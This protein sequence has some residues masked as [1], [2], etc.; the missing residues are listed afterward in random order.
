MKLT[1]PQQLI[2]DS[3]KVIG[4]SVAVMCGIMTVDKVYP[5]EDVVEAIKTIYKTNDALNYCLDDSGKEP[6]MFYKSPVGRKVNVVRVNS[7]SE[8]E[9]IGEKEAATPFDLNGW[10]SELSAV[11]HPEGYGIVLK[12]HHILGDAWSMSLIGTQL[13]AILEGTP[14]VR[15]SYEKYINAEQ[16]Y[17]SSKRYERDR[18]FFLNAFE[19]CREPL[20]LS[21]KQSKSYCINTVSRS[22]SKQM[23]TALSEYAEKKE[24]SEFV[25]LL[26][27]FAVLYGRLKNCAESFF[28]GMPVLN[29][30]SEMDM[31]TVGMYVNT[32]PVPVHFDY[33]KSFSDNLQQIQNTVFSVFKH[34]KFNYNDILKAVSEEYGFQ[35][36]LYDCTVNYETD[37][38][39][40]TKTMRSKEYHREMQTESLQLFIQHRN[41]GEELVVE[42]TFHRDVFDACEMER[43]HDMFMRVLNLIMQDDKQPLKDISIID[44]EEEKLLKS[45]N[46]TAVPYDKTKSVYDLFEEQA[47]KTPDKTAVAAADCTLSYSQLKEE[48]SRL[49]KG[50][51]DKGIKKGDIVA[52]CL[53]RNSKI[54]CA[55]LAV[56]QTGAAYLPID[57]QQPKDRIEYI[58]KDSG[59]KLCITEENYASLIGAEA[60]NKTVSVCGED[61]CYCIYTSG[62]T[63]MPKGVLISHSN[64][65]A[66]VSSLKRIYGNEAVNMPFFTSPGVDL[67]VTSLYLPL[68]SGGTV[69]VY[70]D[71]LNKALPEIINN[72]SLNVIKLTPAHMHIMRSLKLQRQMNNIKHII[73]GG[74]AL[75]RDDVT[76]F[77]KCLGNHMKVHNEYGPTETTVGCMDYEF[78]PNDKEKTVSIGK[79]IAN[80]Q[81]Y[82]VDK[83]M[84]PVPIGVTGELCIA[85]DNVGQGYLNRPELTKEKF[86]D[87]PFGEGKLYKTGDLAYWREDGNIVFVGR[88][89]FQVKINGQRV[90]LGEI[91]AALTAIEGIESAAV[92]VRNEDDRQLLCAFYTGRE[93]AASELRNLLSKTLPRYM[94]PQAFEHL[95]EMPLNA[96]GKTD[97]KALEQNEVNFVSEEYE[98]PE[99]EEEKALA[100]VLSDVLGVEK[101]GRNDNYFALGGDSIRAIRVASELYRR[102][103]ELTVTELMQG[104][105]LI[106]TALSIKSVEA[107]KD[108]TEKAIINTT[109]EN[110]YDLT[111]AQEGMYIQSLDNQ[112]TEAYQLY[113]LFELD[114]K[115]DLDVLQQAIRFLAV[116]HPA[117]KTAFED[118]DGRVKQVIVSDRTPY[119]ESIQINSVY[120]EDELNKIVD[121]KSAYVFDLQKD[122]L[123]RCSFISFSDKRYLFIHM[124]HLITDGWS[125]SVLSENISEYYRFLADNNSSESLEEQI[126]NERKNSTSF[127]AYVNLVR[128][129][130]KAA[131]KRYWDELI[132]DG[133][134]CTI[135]DK[136]A[137]QE[138]RNIVQ[139][140]ITIKPEIR[141]RIEAF[142]RDKH[143]PVNT[144]LECIFSLMLHEYTGM[145]D[146]I[147]NKTIS[148]KSAGL[149]KLEQTVGPMINTIPV[150]VSYSENTTSQ[151]YINQIHSQ[152]VNANKYGF[153]SLSDIYRSN[154]IDPNTV[155][156]L[157]IFENYASPF[158]KSHERLM[159]LIGYKEVT[160]FALTATISPIN[161][162]YVLNFI[163]DNSRISDSLVTL[164][165]N[166]FIT[167]AKRFVNMDEASA[168]SDCL[169][170]TD[171]EKKTV[172]FDFNNTAVSYDKTKSVY[173]LFEEQAK[174]NTLAYIEDENKKYTLSELDGAASKVDAYIRKAVG[175][176]KQVIGVICERSFDELAAIFGIIR[177]GNAYMPISPDYPKERIETMLETSGCRLVIAQKKYC[178]L[179]ESAKAVEDILALQN[180]DIPERAAKAEDTLYVIYTS[181]STGTPKG[182][183]VSNRSA[184]NRIGWMADKYFDSSSVVMLKTPYTFDVSA[185]EILGFAMY[186]FSLY[187]LPPDMHYSQ[188]E[189]LNHI[190]KGRVTDLHFVPTV[191]EQ[192]VSVLKNTPDAKQKLSSLKNVILSG[193]SLP[194]KAVNDFSEACSGRIKVHNLYGPAECAIDVTSYDCKEKEADP[195]PIGKPI[196][197]TQIYIVD[198]YMKP[199]PIGVTGELCIAGDN[200]GQ[201]YLNRPELTAEKFIDNPFGEGKLYKTGD[202]AYWKE[203]GNIVFVGRNDFQVKINGQRVEL[204][205]IEAALTAI[206]GIESAAV[207]VKNDETG[208]QLLCAFYTG[209]EIEASELRAILS[210][211]LPRYMIPQAFEHLEEMPLNAS[212]KTDRKALEQNEVNFVSEEYEAPETEEEKALAAVLSNVLGVDKVGRNDNYFALGGDSIRAIRVVSELYRR[213][214]E[215]TVTELMRGDTL[216][217]AASKVKTTKSESKAGLKNQDNLIPLPPIAGAYLKSGSA[218]LS[219]FFQSCIVNVDANIETL[220]TSIKQ[221]AKRHDM[222]RA[223]MSGDLLR[224][225]DEAE[226]DE[227]F[228][229]IDL[230][231]GNRVFTNEEANSRLLERSVQFSLDGGLLIDVACCKTE[232]NCLMRITL[233]HYI[234][235]LFSWE[236]LLSDFFSVLSSIKKQEPV[237]LPEKTASYSEWMQTLDDYK[238]AMPPDE[239]AYW[240]QC[241][242]R[243]EGAV[244]LF[245]N[246]E[247]IIPEETIDIT[248]DSEVS[249]SL[250]KAEQESNLRLDVLLL[251]ALGCAAARLADGRVGICVE[252]H[253]RTQLHKPLLIDRTVGWFTS[254]YP[255]TM[256]SKTA[257]EELLHNTGRNLQAVPKNGIGW[258]LKYE[259]LPQNADLLFNFYRYSDD[260]DSFAKP[261]M[262]TGEEDMNALFPGMISVDCE[263]RN[264]AVTVHFRVPKLKRSPELMQKLAQGFIL[265]AKE[266]SELNLNGEM[267]PAETEQFSDNSLSGKEWSALES[268][269]NRTDDNE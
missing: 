196:A 139:R 83:Y 167:L 216:K 168:I 106:D 146:L 61:I 198:K 102:G 112:N 63:G 213:G 151:D 121:E 233:H 261:V 105:T 43:F 101:V 11:I 249:S 237:I 85:G 231:E 191:F 243:A 210:K 3:E 122:S 12:V 219:R 260:T 226:F 76:E 239:V 54:P 84:K 29:R 185:W 116:R 238:T 38:I 39:Y 252:S 10:L 215:L 42:Y 212:G 59:A 5:E 234:V 190:E 23:R 250:I 138:E 131:M 71:E 110:V 32:V 140:E 98:A 21:D 224:V 143:I 170:L 118:I 114:E 200:V 6:Q 26:A 153:L 169:Q 113:Y 111:P 203:D 182:A 207:I 69:Y 77:A 265:A 60:F 93:T 124:H 228:N 156:V 175:N 223:V 209:K 232:T 34:Q 87:N 217:D 37:E 246:A 97:R 53:P 137:K 115:T 68:I 50:L 94:I 14:W 64:A 13:N 67:S 187:I 241:S 28:V 7:L 247:S 269:F 229:I 162:S 205:E 92:I 103:Y 227:L 19:Q 133:S 172:L 91:E 41:R 135:S 123:M 262:N 65:L 195:I 30:F 95:E 52:F 22:M 25:C 256:D 147:Y 48:A 74:E 264:N 55:M 36:K 82:I 16:N 166:G 235:D 206:E 4:G 58:L 165:Q 127:A 259:E 9:A 45:F 157:F 90:E 44:E 220:T 263:L 62:S 230:T 222:L 160:E 183:M 148:G 184:I 248:L 176:K 134:P 40:S 130:D 17:L 73:V 159:Q 79:P 75:Y 214:Y 257:D 267:L 8:L 208:A 33:E 141:E 80:T 236:V 117:L 221:L 199:V 245:G 186:G 120:S 171:E 20:L 201:G 161:G 125:M 51:I 31:N 66:Y 177:G 254:V 149:P 15:Y 56:M 178:H 202:L 104:D 72:E 225:L 144:V 35:G 242:A 180:T 109:N 100:A 145:D 88:N 89:D 49:A 24:V 47:D 194:A 181:G 132:A 240:M 78:N 193:E 81:I 253:G 18:Q 251:S 99:T 204:G 96:S 268:I 211:T 86:I 57:P 164:M 244:S 1:K 108:L 150:R 46:N 197:N 70:E 27:A 129:Y 142:S 173:D 192:F 174:N 258:L 266:I 155:D 158:S 189:V 119:T 107:V 154:G 152:S 188:K 179:A 128:S 255:I 218:D 126:Q 163:F 2:Y 136:P